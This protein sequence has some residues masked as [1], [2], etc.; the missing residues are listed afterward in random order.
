MAN[1]GKP[2]QDDSD[3]DESRPGQSGQS[4]SRARDDDSM[5]FRPCDI[6]KLTEE[7]AAMQHVTAKNGLRAVPTRPE[8]KIIFQT[9]KRLLNETVLKKNEAIKSQE[10]RTDYT[11]GAK[12]KF[13]DE[14]GTM[15]PGRY[16]GHLLQEKWLE[17][18]A[19][20]SDSQRHQV[21]VRSYNERQN[22][23]STNTKKRPVVTSPE[24]TFKEIQKKQIQIAKDLFLIWD[25]DGEG[26]LSSDEIMKAFI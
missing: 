19:P 17:K 2:L 25:G 3:A 11:I 8:E 14:M 1:G 12:R 16:L 4:P 6:G 13:G 26:S 22:R 10:Q 7:L 15:G 18:K 23:S 21:R 9:K 20:L 24:Q 5:T